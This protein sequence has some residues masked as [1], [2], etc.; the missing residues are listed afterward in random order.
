MELNLNLNPANI[1]LIRTMDN[2]DYIGRVTEV[3]G[4][5][6]VEKCLHVYAQEA[7]DEA[8]RGTFQVGF[9]PPV[10]PALGQIDEEARGAVNLEFFASGVKFMASPNHQMMEMYSQAT[11]GIAIAKIL[12]GKM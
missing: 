8:N 9:A 4:K 6:H 3:L 1:Q 11:S 12:P 10:H 2:V 5:V 7:T